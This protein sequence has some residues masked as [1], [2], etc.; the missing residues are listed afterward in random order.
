L[1][2]IV[3]R[4][5]AIASVILIVGACLSVANP[6]QARFLQTDPVGYKDDANMYTYVRN[7]PTD[8]VDPSGLEDA[9]AVLSYANAGPAPGYYSTPAGEEEGAETS[10]Q[11]AGM[12]D[13]VAATLMPLDGLGMGVKGEA[14]LMRVAATD[15]RAAAAETRAAARAAQLARNIANGKA[16]EAATRTK[17]GNNIAG[18]QVSFKSSDGTPTRTDFVTTNGGVVESKTGGAQLSAGQAKLHG[19]I[20]AGRPVTPVGNNASG[21]GLTPGQPTVMPSCSVDRTC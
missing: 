15:A 10:E 21:A 2:I 4:Y 5:K 9:S 1:G 19:D 16:G 7:D 20:K 3:D 12:M 8:G 13:A 6:A 18:E 14:M 11:V 17:L